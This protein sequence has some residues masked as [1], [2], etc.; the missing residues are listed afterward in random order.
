MGP[1]RGRA[2]MV[3]RGRGDRGSTERGTPIEDV[4]DQGVA[5]HTQRGGDRGATSHNMRT[6]QGASRGNPTPVVPKAHNGAG[7]GETTA[8]VPVIPSQFARE[9]ATSKL[10]M[11][12]TRHEKICIQRDVTSAISGKL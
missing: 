9:V 3:G 12:R 11:E 7:G 1:K 10:Q 8:N 2:R 4:R 5:S 6:Q